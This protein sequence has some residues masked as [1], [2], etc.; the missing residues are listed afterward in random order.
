MPFL[1][2]IF[3]E[4]TKIIVGGVIVGA[5]FTFVIVTLSSSIV[6]NVLGVGVG[7]IVSFMAPLT[8]CIVANR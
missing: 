8:I 2:F 1:L 6:V 5:F 3:D 7:C 4:S